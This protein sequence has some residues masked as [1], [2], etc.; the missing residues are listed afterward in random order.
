MKTKWFALLMHI[1]LLAPISVIFSFAIFIQ[2][3]ILVIGEKF[4]PITFLF[5]SYYREIFGVQFASLLIYL[6]LGIYFVYMSILTID[7]MFKLMKEVF[8][9]DKKD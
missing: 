4:N 6:L 3:L 1:T 7:T 8:N 9:N 5:N 2:M